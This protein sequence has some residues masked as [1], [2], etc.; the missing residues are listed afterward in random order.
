MGEAVFKKNQRKESEKLGKLNAKE[1]SEKS[2]AIR[3][4][5]PNW[6]SGKLVKW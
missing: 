2:D 3:A 6:I 5:G 1:L 4:L